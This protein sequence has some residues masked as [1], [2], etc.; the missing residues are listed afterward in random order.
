MWRELEAAV[1]FVTIIYLV[2][3]IRGIPECTSGESGQAICLTGVL[4]RSD[5]GIQALPRS[6]DCVC[7][8]FTQYCSQWLES[9]GDGSMRDFWASCCDHLTLWKRSCTAESCCLGL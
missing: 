6:P 5:L 3:S 1:V 9:G 2:C 7:C 4:G 8:L